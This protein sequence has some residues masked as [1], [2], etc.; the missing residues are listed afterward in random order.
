MSKSVA[1][2][3]HDSPPTLDAYV[4]VVG[5]F[6][7]HELHRLYSVQKTL[8]KDHPPLELEKYNSWKAYAQSLPQETRHP[9][10]SIP[11]VIEA[12]VF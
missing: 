11:M 4:L 12:T 2:K 10:N 6:Q 8:M 3:N 7:V 5:F 9:T 1:W